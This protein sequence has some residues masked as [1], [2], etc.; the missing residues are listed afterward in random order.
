MD[1]LL[2]CNNCSSKEEPIYTLSRSISEMLGGP[3]PAKHYTVGQRSCVCRP[4][5]EI[6]GPN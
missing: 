3:D 5:K 2:R 4:N 6:K 1:R